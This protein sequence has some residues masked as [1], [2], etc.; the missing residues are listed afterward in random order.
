MKNLILM[1]TFIIVYF[2]FIKK[3]LFSCLFISRIGVNV[4]VEIFRRRGVGWCRTQQGN[5]QTNEIQRYRGARINERPK[6]FGVLFYDQV[7]VYFNLLEQCELEKNISMKLTQWGSDL[8][9]NHVSYF[10]HLAHIVNL[11]KNQ[12]YYFFI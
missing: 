1:S 9:Y 3:K 2:I 10:Y 12:T 7:I 11:L 6:G 4:R 8:N 5:G